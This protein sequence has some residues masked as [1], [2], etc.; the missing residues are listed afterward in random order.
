M[1]KKCAATI[2]IHEAAFMTPAGKKQIA[3][4]LR[5]QAKMFLKEGD[6]YPTIFRNSY[7]Y[8]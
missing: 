2:T 8:K 6:N 5:K 1:K 4:W 3:D 7:L